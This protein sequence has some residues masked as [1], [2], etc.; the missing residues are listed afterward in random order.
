VNLQRDGGK[1]KAYRVRQVRRV[2]VKY[3]LGLK[4]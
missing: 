1:A 3:N 2:I 4:A